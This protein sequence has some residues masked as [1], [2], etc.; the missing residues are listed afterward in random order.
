ML[1]LDEPS[2]SLD[3]RQRERLWEFVSG[4]AEAGTAVV[5]STHNVGEA[6]RYADRV[7]VLADGELLF[8]GTPARARATARRRRRRVAR[9][10]GRVR[11]ASCA[12]AGPLTVRWLLLKDL[13]ILRRS[14][15]LVA[16]LVVYPVVDRAAGRAR[17]RP[18]G[19]ASR[20]SRSPTSC[21]PSESEF[22]LGGRKLDVA[23]YARQA[24]RDGRP[25]PRR[26]AR[27]GDREG[28][29]RRGAGRARGARRTRPSGC[30][31]RSALGGGEPPTVEV[32]YN[33]EDPLKRQLVETR[34]TRALAD[35]N[36][37]L[38]DAVL[39]E[40]AALHRR[41][42][43]AAGRWR[44]RSSGRSTSSACV[45]PQRII[46]AALATLPKDAPERVALAQVSRF[47]RLAAD[48]LDVSKP[49]LASI[50]TPVHVKQTIVSGAKTSL[51]AFAVAVAVTVC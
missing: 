26:H 40:A 33:A 30:R 51:S 27:G 9:L 24:V 49:I 16:L 29:L 23:D 48:N 1:L 42:R 31:A 5:Y 35:A 34:S 46:E 45:A 19:R 20:R 12:S 6:E 47:A 22:A 15:L 38:S 44:C 43:H 11:R 36:D 50:G 25:D 37:A 39:K 32:Y 3:P 2:A 10:R 21:R 18:P 17:A 28:P 41:D 4:L 13:Q 7:L 14:P 8:S